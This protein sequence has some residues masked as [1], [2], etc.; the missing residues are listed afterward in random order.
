MT[1]YGYPMEAGL[2]AKDVRRVVEEPRT[3]SHKGGHKAA[4][5]P[6]PGFRA[7]FPQTKRPSTTS[8]RSLMT[9]ISGVGNL[10][11]D[12]YQTSMMIQTLGGRFAP[13]G[14]DSL[15]DSLLRASILSISL[16]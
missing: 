11:K 13:P 9:S 1:G 7:A 6:V 15:S 16:H 14:S 12:V 3:S 5:R 4:V 8:P 10:D 2:T